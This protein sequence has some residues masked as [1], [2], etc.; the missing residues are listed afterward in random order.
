MENKNGLLARRRILQS[1]LGLPILITFSGCSDRSE[2][3]NIQNFVDLDRELGQPLRGGKYGFP[4][5]NTLDQ[6]CA[7][8]EH[9]YNEN[10]NGPSPFGLRAIFDNLKYSHRYSPTSIHEANLIH[11]LSKYHEVPPEFLVI[12]AGGTSMLAELLLDTVSK[13]QSLVISH[14]EFHWM[15]RFA[16]SQGA[17]LS[18]VP[19]DEDGSINLSKILKKQAKAGLIYISNPHNPLGRFI[20]KDQMEPFLSSIGQ[21]LPILIDEAYIGYLGEEPASQQTVIN[22]TSK[23]KNLMV[24]R[25]FSKVHGLAGLRVAYSV[26]HPDFRKRF[27]VRAPSPFRLSSLSLVAATAALN[28][29]NHVKKTVSDN[30]ESKQKFEEFARQNNIS[31]ITK[32]V[33]NFLAIDLPSK[34][35]GL[36]KYF[37]S[38]KKVLGNWDGVDFVR[39]SIGSKQSQKNFQDD[40]S[41]YLESMR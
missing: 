21:N 25:T 35:N 30:L 36:V 18:L 12:H 41:A 8:F 2:R 38:K 28:D 1:V 26:S 9:A 29:Q 24:L 17:D 31:F 3:A 7:E 13:V 32:S 16:R 10:A 34:N 19:V 15:A 40:L 23:Y 27:S 22:L 37:N 6:S 11:H 39:L 33:A 5:R 4:S 14:P 20:Q